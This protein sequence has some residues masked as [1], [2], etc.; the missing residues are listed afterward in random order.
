MRRYFAFYV[1]S[2]LACSVVRANAELACPSEAIKL[3]GGQVYINDGSLMP[4]ASAKILEN[5]TRRPVNLFYVVKAL[6]NRSGVIVIK[7]ARSGPT[8]K[9]DQP[10]TGRVDLMR[11]EKVRT[12]RRM[13]DAFHG[14]VTVEAY[15]VYHDRGRNQGGS[16]NDPKEKPLDTLHNFHTS[17]EVSSGSGCLDTDA[18]QDAD[19]VYQRK[20][21][22]SQFSFDPNVVQYG[23]DDAVYQVAAG[24]V[25][26]GISLIF[27]SALAAPPLKFREM[28]VEIRRYKTDQGFACIPFSLSMR[29]A[30]QVL[31]INDLEGRTNAG[32]R[33]PELQTGYQGAPR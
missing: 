20:S 1:I 22:R 11:N 8:L 26:T 4:L 32:E 5:D 13:Q 16:L 3:D 15:E 21:N 30:E 2:L 14:S 28:R 33:A 24:V 27:R 23:I 18:K 25:E 9:G 19:G 7:T 31:R 6:V 29:G 17:Y 12:C 10:D